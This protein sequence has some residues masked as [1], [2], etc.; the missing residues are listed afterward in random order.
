MHKCTDN[1]QNI[2][3]LFGSYYF[4]QFLQ[5]DSLVIISRLRVS[6]PH[7]FDSQL[8]FGYFVKFGHI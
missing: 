3:Q 4:V 1:E 7:H 6:I 5:P 2:F 8:F